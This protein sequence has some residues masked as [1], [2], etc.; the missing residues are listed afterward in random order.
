MLAPVA[1]EVAGYFSVF[2]PIVVRYLGHPL[3]NWA[4]KRNSAAVRTVT[5]AVPKLGTR[6]NWLP[7]CCSS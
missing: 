5:V 3:V 6:E 4:G 1:L 2:S 7:S